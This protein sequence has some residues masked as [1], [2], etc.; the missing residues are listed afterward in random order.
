MYLIL[1]LQWRLKK[2]V[3]NSKFAG[4][5]VKYLFSW[6]NSLK[7]RVHGD[8]VIWAWYTIYIRKIVRW[9]FSP[10]YGSL[11]GKFL[12]SCE[13]Y[14]CTFSIVDYHFKFYLSTGLKLS[15]LLKSEVNEITVKLRLWHVSVLELK[16]DMVSLYQSSGC[17]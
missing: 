16:F 10:F 7:S 3:L 2:A 5:I 13:I 17:E 6:Q 12:C 14:L 15:D 9:S 8:F 11:Q 4:H 1:L